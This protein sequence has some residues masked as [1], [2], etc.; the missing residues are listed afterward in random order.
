MI[1]GS[2]PVVS[3]DVRPAVGGDETVLVVE[4]NAQPRRAAVRQLIALG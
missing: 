3:S 1:S 4:D 2:E